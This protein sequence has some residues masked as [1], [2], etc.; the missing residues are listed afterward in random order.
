MAA[1]PGRESGIVDGCAIFFAP[2]ARRGRQACAMLR[3]PESGNR[4]EAAMLSR[5]LRLPLPLLLTGA[6]GAL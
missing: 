2:S 3:Q 5:Y 1:D 6:L 4:S